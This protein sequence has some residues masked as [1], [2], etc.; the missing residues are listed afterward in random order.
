MLLAGSLFQLLVLKSARNTG[1]LQ[2]ILGAVCEGHVRDFMNRHSRMFRR[3]EKKF[4]LQ[5]EVTCWA[6]RAEKKDQ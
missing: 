6:R 2:A 4:S 5:A 1:L 3:D